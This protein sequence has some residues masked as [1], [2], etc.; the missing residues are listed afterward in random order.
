MQLV[1]GSTKAREPHPNKEAATP[2]A[3]RGTPQK[4]VRRA[5]NPATLKNIVTKAQTLLL[6]KRTDLNGLRP[7]PEQ[8]HDLWI[9]TWNVLSLYRAGALARLVEEI[10]KYNITIASH[11]KLGGNA[12][13]H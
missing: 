10:A 7:R 3:V 9:A 11:K 13:T 12:P 2:S 1:E 5:N 6:N 8:G 4:V